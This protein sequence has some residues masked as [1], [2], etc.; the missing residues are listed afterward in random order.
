[1]AAPRRVVPPTSSTTTR[2]VWV[3]EHLPIGPALLISRIT[4]PC[5]SD[6]IARLVR[7]A[8]ADL[9]ADLSRGLAAAGIPWYLFGAQ[10]AIVY[11][12]ARLT[13]DVDVTARAPDG[14]PTAS[15]LPAVEACGF[16]RRF[17]DPRFIEQSRVVPL[18]H[19]VSGL[20][21]DIVLAGPGLEDEFLAR[22]VPYT[23]DGVPVPV[24]E[25]SD[26]VILKVLAARPKDRDDLTALLAIH[27]GSIDEPRVRRVLALLESALGQSDLLPAFEAALEESER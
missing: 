3:A 13:A 4:F 18:V 12:V 25:L 22:A 7:S 15:W 14:T 2:V 1:M 9:L 19:T 16:D 24:V 6:W 26:L 10:A 20:P 8:V 17:A 11:G 21:V 27:R 5:A 23:I